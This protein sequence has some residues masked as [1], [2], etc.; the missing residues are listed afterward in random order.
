MEGAP[1]ENA[2]PRPA[3]ARSARRFRSRS[4]ASLT[5]ISGSGVLGSL[6]SLLA[7]RS[8]QKPDRELTPEQLRAEIVRWRHGTSM[9]T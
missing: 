6:R 2:F 3:T 7:R 8:N 4:D 1:I 5:A 9:S